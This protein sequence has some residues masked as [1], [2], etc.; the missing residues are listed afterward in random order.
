[1]AWAAIER[2]CQWSAKRKDLLTGVVGVLS[3]EAPGLVPGGRLVVKLIGEVVKHGI[4]RLQDP[5]ADLPEV[6]AAG[7]TLPPGLNRFS[8]DQS[9]E[10]FP[11]RPPQQLLSSSSEYLIRCG[12]STLQNPDCH[13]QREPSGP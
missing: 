7:E 12:I 3:E 4:N 9:G 11:N 1:M 6:K 8:R 10:R 5:R 13:C 2:V